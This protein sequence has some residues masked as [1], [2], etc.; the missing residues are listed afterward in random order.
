M[1]LLFSPKPFKK[2]EVGRR[3]R[4]SVVNALRE[5]KAILVPKI[6]MMDI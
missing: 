3:W 2:L 5:G 1:K 4:D 6:M